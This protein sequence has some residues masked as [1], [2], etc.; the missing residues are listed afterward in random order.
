[1]EP[2]EF[3]ASNAF[4]KKLVEAQSGRLPTR[5]LISHLMQVD[6]YVPSASTVVQ[7]GHGLT[8]MMFARNGEELMAVFTAIERI[9]RDRELF[10]FCLSMSGAKLISWMPHQYGI[11]INPGYRVGMEIP[12]SGVRDIR[13]D[14]VPHAENP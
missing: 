11:V 5:D 8:P 13:R 7:S 6:L 12:A 14:F 9:Y 2:S 4:E 3:V 1:M 10:P